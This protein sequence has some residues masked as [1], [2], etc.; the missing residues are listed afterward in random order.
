MNNI[1]LTADIEIPTGNKYDLFGCILKICVC[2]ITFTVLS[3]YVIVS[4]G[5]TKGTVRRIY[6]GVDE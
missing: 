6:W 1:A 5:W 3:G 2:V 4:V